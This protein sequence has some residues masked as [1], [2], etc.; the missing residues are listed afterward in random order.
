MYNV[1]FLM[2][3]QSCATSS[4]SNFRVF[5]T[6]PEGKLLYPLTAIPHF[7]L[8]PAPHRPGNH[9]IIF[10]LLYK[11]QNTMCDAWLFSLSMMFSSFIYAVA[12]F[13]AWTANAY[14]IRHCSWIKNASWNYQGLK[15]SF[16][17]DSLRKKG[18]LLLLLS[19][20]SHVRLCATP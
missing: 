13:L 15:I 11:W 2:Y 12:W 3:S 17:K 14:F 8:V 6:L 1:M 18:E 4:L 7:F 19:R 20:F 5:S 10:D 16:L 9:Y